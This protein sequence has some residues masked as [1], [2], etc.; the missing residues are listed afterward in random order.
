[1]KEENKKGRLFAPGYIFLPC[2]QIRP[3]PFRAPGSYLLF[4]TDNPKLSPARQVA[5]NSRPPFDERKGDIFVVSV[6]EYAVYLVHMYVVVQKKYRRYD[7]KSLVHEPPAV[8]GRTAVNSCMQGSSENFALDRQNGCNACLLP[9]VGSRIVDTTMDSTGTP[10][11][12]ILLSLFIPEL[13]SPPADT[14]I[15]HALT[16]RH[17]YTSK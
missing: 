17:R 2:T 3:P 11:Y 16:C 14:H 5:S 12:R 6:F 1:M 9:R 13:V 7:R 15:I 10:T 4:V 8:L